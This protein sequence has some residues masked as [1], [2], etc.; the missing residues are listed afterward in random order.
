MLD[1]VYSEIKFFPF[2]LL[3][4]CFRL[5]WGYGI[6]YV[7]LPEQSNLFVSHDNLLPSLGD[8]VLNIEAYLLYISPYKSCG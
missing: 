6:G 7:P 3:E 2:T 8:L 1:E 5:F 4:T